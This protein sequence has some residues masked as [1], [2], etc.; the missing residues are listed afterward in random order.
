MKSMLQYIAG[1]GVLNRTNAKNYPPGF[2]DNPEVVADNL[3]ITR[4]SLLVDP[5][6]A[7]YSSC[8]VCIDGH[9]RHCSLLHV[10]RSCAVTQMQK[11]WAHNLKLNLQQ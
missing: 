9:V 7:Q 2:C 1:P 6:F 3:A 11:N 4:V 5:R 8:N 10:R